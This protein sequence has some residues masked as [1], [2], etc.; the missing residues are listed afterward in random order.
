L[1]GLRQRRGLPPLPTGIG[2]YQGQQEEML[3]SLADFVAEHI[4][5]TPILATW[6]IN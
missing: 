6:E 2:N 1:N 5:L 3:E 4:D